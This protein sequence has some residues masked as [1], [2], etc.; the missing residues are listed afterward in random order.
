LR[1]F[2]VSNQANGEGCLAGADFV[3]VRERRVFHSTAIQKGAVAA[4][5]IPQ[6]RPLRAAFDGEMHAGHDLVMRDGEVRPPWDPAEGDGFAGAHDDFFA[7]HRS[8]FDFK[9]DRHVVS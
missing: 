3:A 6:Q 8:G 9:D 5:L 1:Q 2:I 4:V 7:G